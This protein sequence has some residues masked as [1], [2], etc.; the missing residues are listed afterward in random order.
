MAQ[1]SIL[2][3]LVVLAPVACA[4]GKVPLPAPCV[5]DSTVYTA[6][7]TLQGLVLPRITSLAMP[8]STRLISSGSY[9]IRILVGV[10]GRPDTIHVTAAS[11]LGS[12]QQVA[13]SAR[14]YT[15]H[16]ATLRGCAVRSWY[17]LRMER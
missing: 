3:V 16:P 17:D 4:G 8:N 1:Y 7:D 2:A 10:R 5:G 13:R 15:F 12:A 9:H 14:F 6:A 11:D